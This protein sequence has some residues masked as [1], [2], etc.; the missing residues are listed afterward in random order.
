[1]PV[2]SRSPAIRLS[3]FVKTIRE[4]MFPDQ[5]MNREFFGGSRETSFLR[6]YNHK[7][8]SEKV[9]QLSGAPASSLGTWDPRSVS[10]YQFTQEAL[11]MPVSAGR[12]AHG[13]RPLGARRSSPRML[14]GVNSRRDLLLADYTAHH[15]PGSSNLFLFRFRR[16][17]AA[18]LAPLAE[19][20]LEVQHVH[21]PHVGERRRRE[22][23]AP[24]GLAI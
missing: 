17:G 9:G 11:E 14:L 15:S 23:P 13:R 5:G 1:M 20:A 21:H 8:G 3:A 4:F 24:V 16:R 10:Q 7:P 12:D 22:R 19:T 18:G 6:R 2:Q